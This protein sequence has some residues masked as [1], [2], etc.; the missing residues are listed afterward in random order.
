MI[1][2]FFHGFVGF[3]RHI[4]HSHASEGVG[5]SLF[6][7]VLFLFFLLL[8]TFFFFIEKK[9]K[10]LWI[11]CC[12]RES[13]RKKRIIM[14]NALKSVKKEKKIVLTGLDGAGKTSLLYQIKMGEMIVPVPT[15]SPNV[16]KIAEDMV[17]WDLGGHENI[18]SLWFNHF[19]NANI[20]VFVVDARF[21]FFFF[22]FFL[23]FSFFFSFSSLLFFPQY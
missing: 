1:L 14:G 12:V 7:K 16:E 22:F 23:S 9:K 8:L 15:L 19:T 10:S 13:R 5:F 6:L 21:F 11:E 3:V 20:V 18:R 4:A 17:V 2:G